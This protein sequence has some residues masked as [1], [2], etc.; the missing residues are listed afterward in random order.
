MA[1][2]NCSEC[3]R[4]ISEHAE[5]CPHCGIK[6]D[7]K[8]KKSKKKEA[9]TQSITQ[10]QVQPHYNI[11]VK[12]E[13]DKKV[14]MSILISITFVM[15]SASCLVAFLSEM[16][17]TKLERTFD[18]IGCNTHYC[19]IS[20]KG[21]YLEIDTNPENILNFSS[22]EAFELIKKANNELGLPESLSKKIDSTT[23]IDGRQDFDF[24]NVSV[25]WIFHPEQGYEVIYE[26][27]E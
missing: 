26:V 19:E 14:P 11:E 16:G 1:L 24:Q 10:I 2:I 23:T 15:L 13:K 9:E 4:Q 12:K 6:V 25:S 7:K 5:V 20:K 8:T 22:Q 21:T 18:K 17:P 27:I 3:K